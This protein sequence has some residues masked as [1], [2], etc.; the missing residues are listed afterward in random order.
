MVVQFS[1]RNFG[2]L[3][4]VQVCLLLA[5]SVI[6]LLSL[7]S[8]NRISFHRGL[9]F[10]STCC[11]CAALLLFVVSLATNCSRKESLNF[12]KVSILLAVFSLLLFLL[13]SQ[14]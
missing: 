11:S 12:L 14:A 1:I 2:Y 10:G 7:A 8:N 13:Q 4:L 6:G 5:P 9:A 3:R